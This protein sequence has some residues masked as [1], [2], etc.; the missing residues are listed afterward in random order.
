MNKI[1]R[2]LSIIIAI[3]VITVVIYT[4]YLLFFFNYKTENDKSTY[5]YIYPDF[6]KKDIKRELIS[7][8][9]VQSTLGFDIAERLFAFKKIRPGRY[10]LKNGMNSI[11]VVRMLR[12]GTQTPLRLRIKP[13]RTT[14]QLAHQLSSQ[15]MRDSVAFIKVLKDTSLLGTYNLTPETA[16]ALFIPNSYDIFWNISPKSLIKRMHKEYTAF[17]NQSRRQKAKAIPLSI[18]EVNILSTIVDSETNNV[19]EK[20]IIAGLYINRLKK[21]IPLQADPTVV[22]AVRDFTIR[23]ILL[24]HIKVDSPYNTYINKGLPL[25]P[26]RTPTK[27]GID[28]VLNY[29]KN[30]YLFMCA[31]DKFNGEHNFAKTFSKHLSNARKYQRAK[32]E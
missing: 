9:D 10:E 13:A 29:D 4:T 23:R 1:I 16:I 25:G 19:K 32:E 2:T 7:Q 26:I 21:G 14:E 31:S 28:A 15:L 24:K 18:M 8:T 30:N 12:N 22:F 3:L 6:T 20:P 17:W 5:L 27:S 11:S